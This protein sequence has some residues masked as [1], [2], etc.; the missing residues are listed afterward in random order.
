MILSARPALGRPA[1]GADQ[2]KG[3]KLKPNF[4]PF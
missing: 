1:L 2:A 4:A 3:T